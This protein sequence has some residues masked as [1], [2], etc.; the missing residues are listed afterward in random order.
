M[1]ITRTSAACLAAGA[2]ALTLAACGGGGESEGEGDGGVDESELE[3]KDV[4]A[5]ED[6]GVGDT[7]VAT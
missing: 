6:F 4:G 3:G 7:F 1:R 5:M 2:L